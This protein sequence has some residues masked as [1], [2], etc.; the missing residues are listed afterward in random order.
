MKIILA[1]SAAVLVAGCGSVPVQQ[2]DS[3]TLMACDQRKVDQVERLARLTHATVRWV[4]CPVTARDQMPSEP[5]R[6]E[7]ERV[8]TGI[9]G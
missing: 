7:S 9:P 5:Q 8:L 3:A 6:N 4:R 2:A 1:L